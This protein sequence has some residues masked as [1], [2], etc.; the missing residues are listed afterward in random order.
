MDDN[1]LGLIQAAGPVTVDV[2][3]G[4]P[5]AGG[6]DRPAVVRI[7]W[8]GGHATL[9]QTYTTDMD[10][11]NA[12]LSE[13]AD[14]LPARAKMS[15]AASNAFRERDKERAAREASDHALVSTLTGKSTIAAWGDVFVRVADDGSA[16]LLDPDKRERGMGFRFDSLDAVWRTHPALRPVRWGS[17]AEGPFLILR[18]FAMVT[19]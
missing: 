11:S 19:A 2:R 17:D 15:A 14:M 6:P 4:E 16:W 13:I 1:T 18:A 12:I 10:T 8:S 5:C 9:H 3:A 7:G